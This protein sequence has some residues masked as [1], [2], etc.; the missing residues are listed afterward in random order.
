VQF[1]WVRSPG[2]SCAETS[3]ANEISLCGA[4]AGD[5]RRAVRAQR[6]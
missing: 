1:H 2:A 6:V 4:R 3:S 5:T